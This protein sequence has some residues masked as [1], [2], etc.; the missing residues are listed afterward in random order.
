[1]GVTRGK[2]RP[3]TF[4]VGSGGIKGLVR[5]RRKPRNGEGGEKVN[6]ALGVGLKRQERETVE[7]GVE[8]R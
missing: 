1:L 3:L 6:F 8:K 5:N 2:P 4:C 7:P